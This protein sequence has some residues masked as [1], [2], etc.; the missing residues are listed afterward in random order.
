MIASSTG[1]A[2]EAIGRARELIAV[3]SRHLGDGVV[4]DSQQVAYDLAHAAAAME[5]ATAA[6]AYGVHGELER[7]LADAF[8]ADA[9]HDLATRM[10]GR[11]TEWGLE[12]GALDPAMSFVR[13]NRSP[14][15]LASLVGDGP[16]HLDDDMEMVQATFRRFTDER[17]RP[18]A[19]HVHRRNDDIP[20]DVVAGLAELGTFG[21]TIP[22]HYGG[23]AADDD[24]GLL[25][26]VVATE[27][28]SRG[29]LGAAGSLITRPEILARALLDGATEDQKLTWL[30]RLASGE[31]MAAFAGTEPDHGSDSGA[32]TTRATG[33]AD[34]GFA[35]DGVKT[36]C[37]FA[38]R[39][40]VLLVMARTDHDRS[41]AHRGVSM[42]LVPK[43]R[44]AGHHFRFV[45]PHGGVLE[46]RAIDT[47][48]YRGCT[49]TR[50]P[51]A[52]G[53]SPRTI[54]SA[55]CRARPRVLHA[56]GGLRQRPAPD[57]RPR[58]RRHAGFVRGGP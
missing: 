56:D 34:G 50:S 49:P 18:I 24:R 38:G 36:W 8:V 54:S 19:E 35:I 15:V 32:I 27:E 53:A 14:A 57:R 40:D 48:G 37:T 58:R 13:V 1:T 3:A 28:L 17:V 45:Q 39:A 7:R 22:E 41:K 5:V 4:D 52:T 29:S 25:A 55:G 44:A 43:P 12:P 23:Y 42:F 46:G 2:A 16:R 33:V 6:D 20:D 30:P 11:E 47:I 26:M 9:V 31:V 51:S 10:L 21:L